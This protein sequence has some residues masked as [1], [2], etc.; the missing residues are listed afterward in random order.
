MERIQALLDVGK[1]SDR[2]A[3]DRGYQGKQAMTLVGA[4]GF[5]GH[6]ELKSRALIHFSH[7][8]ERRNDMVFA[9]YANRFGFVGAL[10]LLALYSAWALGAMWIAA[11]CKDAFGRLVIVGFTAMTMTQMLINIG[12]CQGILPITGMTLPFISYGGSSLIV[13][14]L[15]VGM[16]V[17][18]AMR[19]PE[20]FWKKSFEFDDD[21]Q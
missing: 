18:I 6:D 9:V 10:W 21:G 12:E 3:D 19:K 17:N 8:P 5:D 2:Y 20:L 15:M 16:M 11:A 4:G 7:L 13:G 14:F 1:G